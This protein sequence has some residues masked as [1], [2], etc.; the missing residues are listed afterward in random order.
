[1]QIGIPGQTDVTH[2]L[3]F[4]P[5][6]GHF[7]KKQYQKCAEQSRKVTLEERQYILHFHGLMIFF[8]TLSTCVV[9]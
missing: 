1:M 3:N 2:W 9:R 4:G 8:A 5:I 7:Y 6:E